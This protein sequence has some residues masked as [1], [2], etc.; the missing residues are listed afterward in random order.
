MQFRLSHPKLY[1]RVHL[2]QTGFPGWFRVDYASGRCWNLA[3]CG[4]E[5]KREFGF[6]LLVCYFSGEN[7]T[8]VVRV[9]TDNEAPV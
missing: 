4:C 6:A 5:L 1:W 2:S 9:N 3:M 7:A 8:L